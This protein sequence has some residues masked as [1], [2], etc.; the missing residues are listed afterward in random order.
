MNQYNINLFGKLEIRRDERVVEGGHASKAQELLCYLLLHRRRP[1][2]RESLAALFWGELSTSHSKKYLRQT[3]WQI[4]V[5]LDRHAVTT[6]EG[7]LAI[8][9]DWV[10]V[11]ARANL[12]LD[13]AILEQAFT[14]VE[15]V[16]GRALD[17][18][19]VRALEA[20]VELY[21]GDLLEGWYQDWCLVERERL[22]NAYMVIL[23]KLMDYYEE[24]REYR[25]AM[26]YGSRILA[27]DQ[28]HERTHQRLMLLYYLAG[29]RA[30]ALRQY[31]RCVEALKEELAVSPS[32]RTTSLYDQIR[33]DALEIPGRSYEKGRVQAILPELITQ[34]RPGVGLSEV[35]DGLKEL[36]C[37]LASIHRQLRQHI[38]L[39]ESSLAASGESGEL[40]GGAATGR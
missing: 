15:Q 7:L 37:S 25:A 27:L 21:R 33:A 30:G 13:V 9:P 3:L 14:W 24:K 40:V 31:E 19:K 18:E 34:P 11:N 1:H 12:C 20:A 2:P 16:P 28:A 23:D 35:L 8:G 5:K 4:Q 38:E 22:Q 6:G 10:G 26:L 29:D 36:E 17:P 32:K 39:V